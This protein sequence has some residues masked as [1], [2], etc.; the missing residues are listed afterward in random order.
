[1]EKKYKKIYKNTFQ[2]INYKKNK[3]ITQ[4]NQL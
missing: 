2:K 3:N 1:M 4:N